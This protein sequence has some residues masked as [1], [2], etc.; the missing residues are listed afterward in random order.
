[1]KGR[2]RDAWLADVHSE[3]KRGEQLP[4]ARLTAQQVREI[5]AAHVRFCQHNGAPALA[6]RYGVHRRTVEKIL[7]FESWAHV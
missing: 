4:Q 7:A 2:K 5:R 1:M 3:A 6:R